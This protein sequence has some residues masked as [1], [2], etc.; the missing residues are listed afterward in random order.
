MKALFI[1]IVLF[2]CNCVQAQEK[3]VAENG[4]VQNRLVDYQSFSKSRQPEN[5]NNLILRAVEEEFKHSRQSRFFVGK[6]NGERP[7][8]TFLETAKEAL[9]SASKPQKFAADDDSDDAADA[10]DAAGQIPETAGEDKFHWKPALEQSGL[11]LGIQHGFRLMQ[12]RTTRDLGGPFFPDWAHSVRNLRGWADGD[13]F[14]IN[15]FAHPMQGAA[16]GRIFINNSDKSKRLEFGSSKDYWTSRMKAMAWSAAW[17]T[18]FELGPISEASI[19][20]VGIHDDFGP[21]RMGWVDLIIT[22]TAG[23]GVLIG[24]DIIDKYV[25]RNWLETRTT[26]RTKIKMYR[27]L[28]TPITSFANIL[29]FKKPWTRDNR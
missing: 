27:S 19:G 4:S 17:S 25:L 20:N 11:F 3:E 14:F 9:D 13:I 29:R 5:Q 7:R 23:T 26:S 18:Q 1:L 12:K 28:F 2:G 22:P 10:G 15:Y 24:E 6:P 8:L 21:S 16:T